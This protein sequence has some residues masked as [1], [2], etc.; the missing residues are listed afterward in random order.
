MV[1]PDRVVLRVAGYDH[2]SWT[3]I[4]VSRSLESAV[5][6][7]ALD[8]A[9]ETPGSVPLVAVAPYDDCE[10]RV[11]DDVL[12]TGRVYRVAVSSSSDDYSIAVTGSSS[13][14]E[15]E[16]CSAVVATGQVRGLRLVDVAR[17]LCA[18]HGID[19]V[20]DAGTEAL[21]PLAS[22]E[23]TP[24][25]TAY[26]VVERLA[27]EQAVLVTDDSSGRLVLSRDYPTLDIGADIVEGAP[28]VL[29]VSVDCDGTKRYARVVVTGQ[30]RGTDADADASG[31]AVVT[32]EA[33]DDGALAGSVLVIPAEDAIDADGATLRATWEAA[34]R[35]ARST[36]VTAE[37]D[38]WRRADGALW[39]PGVIVHV[40][41]QSC[42]L[43]ADL[44][45]VSCDYEIGDDGM[46]TSIVLS[47]PDAYVP[48]QPT[49]AARKAAGRPPRKATTATPGVD[50][51]IAG[52]V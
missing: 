17:L 13:T 6:T 9:E 8:L 12:L 35:V 44:L 41:S 7:F 1:D 31:A 49:T 32:G 43:D 47:P 45:V 15:A 19:V 23:I 27:R 16:R 11:G 24:G 25:E 21:G 36:V 22:V 33:E 5:S 48:L 4:R 14:H 10:I 52:E 30:R 3:A 34:A 18:A 50:L 51:W 2:A 37:V 40:V 39:A 46:Q 20:A 28:G 42:R 26:E 38:G 29:S